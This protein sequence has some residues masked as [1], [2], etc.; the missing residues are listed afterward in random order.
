MRAKK[1]K[2][3]I[4]WGD[5]TGIKNTTQHGRCYAPKGKTPVQELP[6]KR[7]LLNMISAITNQGEVRFMLYESSMNAKA[8][9]K[10]LRALIESTPSKVFLILDNLRV[11]ET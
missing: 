3:T 2:A 6:D 7:V 9:I 4:F 10:F 5:G 1:E 8:L 11:S